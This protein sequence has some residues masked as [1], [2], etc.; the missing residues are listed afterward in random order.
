MVFANNWDDDDNEDSETEK[1][2]VDIIVG[3]TSGLM[4]VCSE[5]SGCANIMWPIIIII[6]LIWCVCVINNDECY[7]RTSNVRIRTMGAGM[8]GY[9]LGSA[10]AKRKDF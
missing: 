9:Y 6:L 10:M 8:S 5:Y 1:I 3:L 4:G 2:I 7:E